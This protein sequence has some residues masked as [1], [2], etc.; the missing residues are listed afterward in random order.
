MRY[1]YLDDFRHGISVFAIFSHGIAVLGTPQCPPLAGTLKKRF[2]FLCIPT[3]Q[4]RAQSTHMLQQ[5]LEYCSLST[6]NQQFFIR[7]IYTTTN[8]RLFTKR[9]PRYQKRIKIL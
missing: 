2:Y 5:C 9:G 1:R 6:T 8:Q 7:V 4:E 3:N